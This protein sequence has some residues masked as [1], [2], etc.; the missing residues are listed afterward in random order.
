MIAFSDWL[1]IRESSPATRLKRQAALGLAP[2]VADIFSRA[3]P[4][5]WQVDRLKSALKKSHSKK[6]KKKKKHMVA[7][8]SKPQP[9]NKGMDSFIAAIERL[10]KDL[11]ELRRLKKEKGAKDSKQKSKELI[12]KVVKSQ[13]KDIGKSKDDDDAKDKKK[14]DS[15]KEKSKTAPKP[16]KTVSKAMPKPPKPNRKTSNRKTV[17]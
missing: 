3:T 6:R 10:A 16:S 13:V 9:I 15:K 12:K 7:E 5:P 14:T 11:W 1:K 2:P 8:A 17:D 4:P